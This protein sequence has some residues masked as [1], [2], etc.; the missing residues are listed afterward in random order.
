[1]NTPGEQYLAPSMTHWTRA[2]S[3]LG[4]DSVISGVD[5]GRFRAMEAVEQLGL[6]HNPW[7]ITPVNEFLE[8]PESHTADFPSETR[9]AIL[10]S[11]RPN[12]PRFRDRGLSS[13]GICELIYDSLSPAA[14]DSYNVILENSPVYTYGGNIVC[15][16]SGA[17]RIEMNA[18]RDGQSEI[19]GSK[20]PDYISERDLIT[21]FL[22]HSFED[23][24][25]RRLVWNTLLAVPHET[26]NGHSDDFKARG[27]QFH[28]GYYEFYLDENHSPRFID[29]S[30]QDAFVEID[31][32]PSLR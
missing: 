32:T 22:K 7:A 28:P 24:Q 16:K 27:L 18:G 1:M 30:D 3:E 26:T 19:V 11:R 25:I 9:F 14:R 15:G 23:E 13:Q 4:L 8:D 21:G 17:V 31:G 5:Q 20:L 2:L 6:P 12:T 10:A 29:Y